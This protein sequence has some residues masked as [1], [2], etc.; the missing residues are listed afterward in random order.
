MEEPLRVGEPGRIMITLRQSDGFSI[1][2]ILV[3]R[4]KQGDVIAAFGEGFELIKYGSYSTEINYAPLGIS[5]GYKNDDPTKTIFA[6]NFSSPCQVTT[7]REISLN[8]SSLGDVVLEYVPPIQAWLTTESSDEWWFEY[9][10]TG[11]RFHIKKIAS[12]PIKYPL[13]NEYTE[14]HRNC[15]ISMIVLIPPRS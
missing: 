6:I 1:R 10:L 7:D 15:Q 13:S 12:K 14:A 11:I 5:F 3:G 9:V 2:G 8:K 4:S